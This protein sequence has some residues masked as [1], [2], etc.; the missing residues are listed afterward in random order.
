MAGV[1]CPTMKYDK[2]DIMKNKI[3][4]I[5]IENFKT[6]DK[7]KIDGLKR[8]NLISGKNNLGKTAVLEAIR[9]NVSSINIL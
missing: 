3:S 5:E 9:L 1:H 2:E 7:L 4:F 8:V 6:F